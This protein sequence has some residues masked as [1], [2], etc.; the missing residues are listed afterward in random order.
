MVV[1]AVVLMALWLRGRMQEGGGLS[2]FLGGGQEGRERS[3]FLNDTLIACN[4][5]LSVRRD[6]HPHAPLWSTTHMA[7]ARA[8]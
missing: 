1:W 6:A 2:I 3:V 8:P 4:S 5:A 7:L